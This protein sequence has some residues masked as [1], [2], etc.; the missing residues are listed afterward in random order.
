MHSLSMAQSILQAAFI[1]AEK[2]DGRR[3]K[4]VSIKVGDETFVEADS[5]QFCLEA[6]ARGT[7]AEGARVEIEL[8]GGAAKCSECALVFPI[9]DHLPICPRCGDVNL[10]MLTGKELF[11]VTLELE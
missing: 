9:E 8:V 1:E 2:C 3:I 5:L 7:I 10:E 4:A 11:L 6:M